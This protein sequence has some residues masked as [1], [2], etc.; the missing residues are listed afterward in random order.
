MTPTNTYYKRL[1][2]TIIKNLERR[3]MQAHYCPTAAEAVTLV[4]ELIPGGSLVSFGGSMT[5]KESGMTEA[6]GH[7]AVRP[8]QGWLA[9]RS[10]RHLSQSLERRLFPYE[11]QRHL[12]QRRASKYRRYWKPPCRPGLWSFQRH[13]PS[14]NEQSSPF[15]R[16]RSLPC[17]KYRRSY[18]CHTPREKHALRRYWRMF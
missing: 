10:E 7:H 15:R 14:R 8:Q 3:Q 9:T 2:E 5:L 1:A 17:Q 6:S 13:H 11:Q 4:T 12:H 18:Q 16:S